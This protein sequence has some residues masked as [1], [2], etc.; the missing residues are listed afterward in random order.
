MEGADLNTKTQPHQGRPESVLRR[1]SDIR[2]LPHDDLDPT[3]GRILLAKENKER[4]P[5]LVIL[6][7]TLL[8]QVS[9]SGCVRQRPLHV[10]WSAA[11]CSLQE[12]LRG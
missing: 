7:S 4:R 9:L 6:N 1:V 8:P 5:S 3:W 2:V 10:G 11:L 12:V